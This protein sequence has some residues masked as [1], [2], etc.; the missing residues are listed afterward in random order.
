MESSLISQ[1]QEVAKD[2]VDFINK[3]VSPWHVVEVARQRL[4]KAGFKEI[5]ENENWNLEP[6][7]K[8]F[9]TR[10]N[11]TLFAFTVGGKFDPNNTGFKIIGA[12]SDSPCLRLTPI[13]KLTANNFH[14]A[15][16][17]TYGGGL[18]HTWFDRDLTVAGR[19]IYKDEK[20][21]LAEKLVHIP[22]PICV[23]PN[24]CI[25]Y[26][27]ADE[28][29]KMEPNPEQHLRPIFATE[30]YEAFTKTQDEKKS[31]KPER[32]YAGLL[33]AL[34][35]ESG[36]PVDN[37]VD[38]EL[39]FADTQPS[40][41]IGI[42]NE[43][44][45]SPRLDNLFSSYAT[46]RAIIE[47]DSYKNSTY[48][49][50]I[51]IFD[52]EEIGSTS[53]QGADSPLLSKTM[54][55][56]FKVLTEKSKDVKV[57]A[58]D[59]A[60]KRSF[61]ISADQAHSIHPNYSDKHQVNHQVKINKGP[62]IKVNANQRYATDSRGVAL[63]KTIAE[64]VQVPI[65]EI[66]NKNDVPCGS[67]I[68]P[69]TAGQTGLKVIDIGCAQLAMHSIRETAGVLDAYYYKTLMLGFFQH[70]ESISHNLFDH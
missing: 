33:K 39:C 47:D 45:C 67:T 12:H 10:N 17:Q 20:G 30:I 8:Y 53:H 40:N 64:K 43:F 63:L 13:S 34:S 22:R 27:K 28:R 48:V 55:R 14:Q 23:V 3:G 58:L 59:V 65:Q 50:M 42:N 38:L 52:H 15:C 60:L 66:V 21:S 54:D 51:C 25:H 70:F 69:L 57:D 46:I 61:C 29:N 2:C 26:R 44:I 18:W 5:R 41:I 24:L 35:Q 9:F 37:I 7:G 56:I 49:N 6:S 4:T 62:V 36:V 1:S 68:G 19:M 31:D 16:V 11:T 32:H